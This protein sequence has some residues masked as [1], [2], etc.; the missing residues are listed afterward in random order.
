MQGSAIF[1]PCREYRYSLWRKWG[2]LFAPDYK[3][4]VMFIGLNPST[5]DENRDDPTIR[6]CI[7]FTKAWG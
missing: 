6:R 2:G 4:Y 5:A 1:S 3:G 7:A